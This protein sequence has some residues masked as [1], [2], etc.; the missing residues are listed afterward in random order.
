[1]VLPINVGNRL[2]G[3]INLGTLKTSAVRFN[4]ENVQLMNKLIDLAIVA[5]R[6]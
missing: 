3:V 6:E 2:I 5:L 4:L 1:M